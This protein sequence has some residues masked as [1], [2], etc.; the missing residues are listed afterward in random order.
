VG[1]LR[2]NSRTMRARSRRRSAGAGPHRAEFSR[3][4]NDWVTALRAGVRLVREIGRQ[5]P[6]ASFTTAEISSGPDCRPDAAIDAHIRV[7]AITVQH[8]LCTCRMELR[9]DRRLLECWFFR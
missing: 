2:S 1:A 9:R 8:P 5:T 4:R 7:T 6:L 3:D